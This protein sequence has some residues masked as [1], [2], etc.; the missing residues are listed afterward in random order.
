M[1]THNLQKQW[2]GTVGVLGG[3]RRV[4]REQMK[5]H[6]DILSTSRFSRKTVNSIFGLLSL[7]EASEIVQLVVRY[8]GVCLEC[9]PRSWIFQ[10]IIRTVTC[11]GIIIYTGPRDTNYR[12]QTNNLL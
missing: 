3:G 12:I 6:K 9:E 7:R 4:G 2:A 11:E 5:Q 10:R 8:I 1:A